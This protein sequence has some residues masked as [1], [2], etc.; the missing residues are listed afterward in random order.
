MGESG[1]RWMKE[2]LREEST[3]MDVHMFNCTEGVE[4]LEKLFPVQVIDT[5]IYVNLWALL[6]CGL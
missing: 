2:V 5:E 4:N 6:I 3:P 1:G